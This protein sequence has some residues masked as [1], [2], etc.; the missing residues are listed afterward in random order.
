M[1]IKCQRDVTKPVVSKGSAVDAS[2]EAVANWIGRIFKL[3]IALA[4]VA[5]IAFSCYGLYTM[6]FASRDPFD[7]YPTSRVAAV[8]EL[9]NALARDNEKG[10]DRALQLI[11]FRVRHG[12]A[13]DN[14]DAFFHAAFV[15]MHDDFV[16]KYS[17]DWLSKA[18]VTKEG[19]NE[20]E[21]TVIISFGEDRYGVGVQVQIPAEKALTDRLSRKS[22]TYPE[23][24]KRHF[25][26]AELWEYP[27][28]PRDKDDKPRLEMPRVLPGGAGPAGGGIPAN[29]DNSP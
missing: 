3:G 28:H 27:W 9:L 25:G 10:Y 6:F 14:E 26:I 15:R 11:S 21:E 29:D 8:Q 12:T 7:M 23:D 18:K 4:V 13:N 1:C 2:T 22:E 5:F 20:E 17:D 19:G 16:K 24:G